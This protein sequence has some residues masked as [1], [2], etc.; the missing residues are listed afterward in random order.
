MNSG[1]ENK[2]NLNNLIGRERDRE[3]ERERGKDNN[4]LL[5]IL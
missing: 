4:T 2:N 5:L 3:A 1:R